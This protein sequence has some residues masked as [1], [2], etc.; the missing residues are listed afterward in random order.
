MS[1]KSTATERSYIT[2]PNSENKVICEKC[3]GYIDTSQKYIRRGE[4]RYEHMPSSE[5][6]RYLNYYGPGQPID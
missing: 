5:C 1:Q 2:N 3:G 4:G 6:N